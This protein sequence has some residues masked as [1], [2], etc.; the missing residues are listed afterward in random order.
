MRGSSSGLLTR[1]ITAI[2]GL[3]LVGIVIKLVGSILTPLLP[4]VFLAALT[5]SWAYLY[6]LVSPAIGPLGAATILALLIWILVS[7]RR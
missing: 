3:V 1:T 5:D 6:A 2:A 4:P 7:G